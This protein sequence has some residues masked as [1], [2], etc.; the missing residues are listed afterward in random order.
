[1]KHYNLPYTGGTGSL[2]PL[3]MGAALILLAAGTAILFIR[4]K[5][6]TKDK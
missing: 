4:S 6:N 2:T 5:R 3:Y 1:M